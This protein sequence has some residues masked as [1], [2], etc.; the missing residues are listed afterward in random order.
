MG[1]ASLSETQVCLH[2]IKP[3]LNHLCKRTCIKKFRRTESV[4]HPVNSRSIRRQQLGECGDLWRSCAAQAALKRG[5]R[6]DDG[7]GA[8]SVFE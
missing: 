1:R 2:S 8:S 4:A 7:E 5:L 3:H 6:N